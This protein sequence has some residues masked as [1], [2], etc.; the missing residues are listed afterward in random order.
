MIQRTHLQ[1]KTIGFIGAGNMAQAIIDGLIK[2]GQ[3]ESQIIASNRSVE[4]IN[5]LQKRYPELKNA[6]NNREV[7]EIADIIIIAVKPQTLQEALVPLK[8]LDL[9][10]KLLI[11]VAAG[12]DCQ[13]FE[14]ILGQPLRLVRTMPNTPATLSL[15]ATGMFANPQCG[16]IDRELAEAIFSAVG[17]C[18]WI[19]E[20]SQMDLVTAIAGSAPAYYFLFLEAICQSAEAQGMS[21]ETAKQL[22]VQTALGAAT[23]AGQSDLS[24]ADLRQQVTSPNGTTHAAITDFKSHQ[25]EKIVDSAIRASVNRGKELSEIAKASK[26]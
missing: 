7:A 25:F 14:S 26:S 4:K 8:T 20:E 17:I 2:S 10:D 13:T 9:S 21:A 11:S 22:A 15:S 1:Q 6:A 19:S 3:P 12:V 23:M 16:P 18:S 5:L 24:L